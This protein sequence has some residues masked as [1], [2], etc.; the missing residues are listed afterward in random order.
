MVRTQTEALKSLIIDEASIFK[1]IDFFF[2]LKPSDEERSNYLNIQIIDT[3]GIEY[4]FT[5]DDSDGNVK[6]LLAANKVS[7]ISFRFRDYDSN[8][9]CSLEL[10]AS[11]SSSYRNNTIKV[12]GEPDWSVARFNN[13][14]EIIK[15][16]KPQNNFFAEHSTAFFH[17]LSLS[18]GWFALK[19]LSLIPVVPEEPREGSF[20]AIVVSLTEQYALVEIAI[21]GLLSWMLGAWIVI[22]FWMELKNWISQ[23]WPSIEFDFGPAHLRAPKKIR[24]ALVTLVSMV[25]IPVLFSLF[26]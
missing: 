20:T 8:N 25:V 2:S 4:S 15:S 18:F 5:Q 7:H 21:L 14:K 19:L 9:H 1:I 13:L 23:I 24:K 17:I 3:D 22:M 10:T 12:E 11:N 6:N 16:F 26:L